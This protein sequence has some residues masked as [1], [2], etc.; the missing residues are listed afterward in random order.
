VEW[1]RE[2]G[3]G[4]T[5]IPP[6][7]TLPWPTLVFSSD[8]N[9]FPKAF[10]LPVP[11]EVEVGHIDCTATIFNFFQ[12]IQ[13]LAHHSKVAFVTGKTSPVP[14]AFEF[15]CHVDRQVILACFLRIAGC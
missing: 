1:R 10:D 14:W 9:L 2:V 3:D 5:I 13:T 6:G 4:F 8:F 12:A 15:V 7:R 11:L